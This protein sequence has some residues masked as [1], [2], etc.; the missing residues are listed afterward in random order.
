MMTT[1]LFWFSVCVHPHRYHL[2]PTSKTPRLRRRSMGLFGDSV[3]LD[4]DTALI[5]APYDDDNGYDLGL[6]M[7]SPALAPPGPSKQNSSPQTVQQR[8]I[9][10]IL[11]LLMVTPPSLEHTIDD[12]RA[13]V[14]VRV[15]KRRWKSTTKYTNY[16]WSNDWGK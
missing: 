16:N 4:G 1:E 5:G 9:L 14:C 12:S 7:C 8:I 11:F 15:H 3:S 10:A 2:D 13:W 6:R